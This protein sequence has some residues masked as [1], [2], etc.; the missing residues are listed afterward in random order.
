MWVWSKSSWDLTA[1]IAHLRE[2][3]VVE[4][5]KQQNWSS[6]CLDQ[7]WVTLVGTKSQHYIQ[8]SRAAIHLFPPLFIHC[9]W[10]GTL[11]ANASSEI[12]GSQQV[13]LPLA[14]LLGRL[15]MGDA[16][17]RVIGGT[18]TQAALRMS[19]SHK[20]FPVHISACFF[21]IHTMA[22]EWNGMEWNWM[23]Q[24]RIKENTVE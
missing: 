8:Y 23:E 1:S 22:L 13:G 4:I 12:F 21:K 20:R 24:N 9:S 7:A 3:P 14:A 15:H 5:L 11:S 18:H 17:V 2:I 6:V 16:R 19:Y 10:S